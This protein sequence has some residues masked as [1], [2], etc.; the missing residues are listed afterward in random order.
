MIKPNLEYFIAERAEHLAIVHLT[1]SQNLA[2][3]RLNADYGLDLLASISRDE[4]PTGR[5][6]GIQVKGQDQALKGQ[7]TPQF[8]LSP[9]EHQ[10]FQELPFPVCILFFTMDDDRGYY[11]WIK[12]SHAANKHLR[13]VEADSWKVLNDASIAQIVEEVNHWYDEKSHSAA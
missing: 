11:N 1:R 9:Q 4:S 8:M 6:F 3:E 2:I 12:L 5:I 10:Y 7:Q 13:P